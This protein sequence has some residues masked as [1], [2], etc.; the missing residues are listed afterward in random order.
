VAVA[1]PNRKAEKR[2][3][4]TICPTCQGPV[5]TRDIKTNKLFPF[6][7]E[8]CKLVDLGKWF[9]GEHTLEGPIEE[10]DE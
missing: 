6:C 8:K 1:K 10:E 7:S 2:V 3:R 5:E 9:N 4:R